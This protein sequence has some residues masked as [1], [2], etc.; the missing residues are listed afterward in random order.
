MQAKLKHTINRKE[1]D[2]LLRVT[3]NIEKRERQR[4][5]SDL[6]D[7]VSGD[8]AA[9]QNFITILNRNEKNEFKKS[10]FSEV[11]PTVTKI[12]SDIEN[13]SFDLM[14]PMIESSGLIATLMSYFDRVRKWNGLTIHEQYDTE[15]IELSSSEAYEL[16]KIVR[17]LVTNMMK[18]GKSKNVYFT[19]RTKE[20][21]LVLEIIDDGTPFDF[22]K[23]LKDL[24]GRGLKNIISRVKHIGAE[25]KQIPIDKGNK[26]QIHLKR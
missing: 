4:L 10:I 12:L 16:Y 9:L 1:A 5:A 6:H 14:P 24:N 20:N 3:L 17:E 11:E 19:I 22:Y 2:D 23:S 7:T 13:I 21:P 8:L 18:H 15:N 25:L 26:I